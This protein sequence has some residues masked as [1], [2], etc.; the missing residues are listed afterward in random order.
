MERDPASFSSRFMSLRNCVRHRVTASVNA[1][2]APMVPTVS[3]ANSGP[4]RVPRMYDTNPISN[5]VGNTL[6]T[7]VLRVND[8]PLVPRSMVRVTAPVCRLR[9]ND[10]SSA[11][12]WSNALSATPRMAPCATL[13]NVSL[14]SSLS[15]LAPA[16]V[17]PYPT[18]ITAGVNA[19]ATTGKVASAAGPVMAAPA[20]TASASTAHL[21]ISGVP[22]FSSLE[23]MRKD[24][25][26]TTRRRCSGLSAG[27]M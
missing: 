25:A 27:Q 1:L 4:S 17:T 19:T 26:P 22:T 3:T 2:Y 7:M 13:A 8:T 12:R 20:P 24:S 10:R 9:W 11:C 21:N 15:R 23:P 6:N 14:R 5:A 18:S 16:R